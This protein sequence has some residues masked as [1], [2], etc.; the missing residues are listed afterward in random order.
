MYFTC[1][2]ENRI[3]KPVEMCFNKG[4]RERRENEGA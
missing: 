3:V 1:M 2:Y 4:K